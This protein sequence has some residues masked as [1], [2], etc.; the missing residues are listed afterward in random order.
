MNTKRT[1]ALRHAS[2]DG[3]IDLVA[4]CVIG[5]CLLLVAIALGE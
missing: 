2:R 3:M 5:F 4:F 1:H